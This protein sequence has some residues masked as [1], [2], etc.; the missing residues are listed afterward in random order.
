MAV[1]AKEEQVFTSCTTG[2]P[3]YVYVRNG[4]IT[5]I[6]PLEFSEEH[7]APWV[8]AAR[9][10]KFTPPKT[11]MVSPYTLAERSRIYTSSRIL[12]PLKRVDFNPGGDRKTGNRGSSGYMEISW[13]EALDILKAEIQHINRIY[14]PG[15]ILTTTSS[16]HNWGNIGYRFS[17]HA[18]F[19]AIL[20]AMYA[21]HNPDS[22]EGWHWGAMHTWGFS[23]RLGLSEQYDLLEDALKNTEMI[24]FWSSDP[25]ATSGIYSGRNQP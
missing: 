25:E 18:R 7:T 12:H 4:K 2:G 15:A 3:V 14:G 22:W 19:M 16:H 9:G 6:E 20:G 5:R 17:A 13:D 23:W 1:N 24:V 10:K 21:E 8:I 11:A